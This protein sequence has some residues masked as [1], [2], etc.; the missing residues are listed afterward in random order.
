MNKKNRGQIP[1][2]L[3]PHFQEYNPANLDLERDANLIIQRTL[4]FGTWDDVRW[5]VSLYDAPRIRA[6]LQ[7]WGERQLS[8]VT[9][10]YWR[11]FSKIKRWR[12]SPFSIQ[13]GV[14]WTR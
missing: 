7:Q 14:L 10:N 6:Y 3:L 2:G 4:E 8:R 9:F 5:L 12:R 1:A 13:K 11:K